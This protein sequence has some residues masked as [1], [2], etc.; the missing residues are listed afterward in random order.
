M[1]NA[2]YKSDIIVI[3][4]ITVI[5]IIIILV[6]ITIIIIIIT[7]IIIIIIIIIIK[8]CPHFLKPVRTQGLIVGWDLT[9][10]SLNPRF[11]LRV[12]WFSF[13]HEISPC[14]K[15]LTASKDSNI[16]GLSH[17]GIKIC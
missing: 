11:F 14:P 5:T 16:M 8:D 1:V 7:I 2:L 3:I 4:I 10:V 6:N 9:D 17:V 12:L 15:I 13:L